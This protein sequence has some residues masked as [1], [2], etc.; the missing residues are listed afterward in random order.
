[1]VLMASN[2]PIYD[3]DVIQ[4]VVTK[5]HAALLAGGEF[6]LVGEMLD[7]DRSGPI[8]AALWGM[9]EAL[10]NS[11]GKAHSIA[12]CISYLRQAGFTRISDEVFVPGILHRVSGFKAGRSGI[13]TMEKA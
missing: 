3:E 5:A 11:G 9:N 7:N 2:L 6:H 13:T 4:K 8:D 10:C 12:Q 1:V